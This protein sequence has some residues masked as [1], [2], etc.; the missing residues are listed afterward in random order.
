MLFYC[1]P[2]IFLAC[3]ESFLKQCFTGGVCSGGGGGSEILWQEGK[4]EGR[5]D[6]STT[7]VG[8][9]SFSPSTPLRF[10]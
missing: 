1:I 9:D 4:K 8:L 5:L 6:V 7:P 10:P 2:V 3:S